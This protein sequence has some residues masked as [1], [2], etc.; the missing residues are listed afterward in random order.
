M[1]R[2]ECVRAR[3]AYLRQRGRAAG[4]AALLHRPRAPGGQRLSCL[5][6]RGNLMRGSCVRAGPGCACVGVRAVGRLRAS[7]APH[8]RRPRRAIGGD[9]RVDETRR[10]GRS[11]RV[12][13]GSQLDPEGA[14]YL[15]RPHDDA[16]AHRSV[17]FMPSRRQVAP[18]RE[19]VCHAL[20]AHTRRSEKSFG[21][22][23]TR[24]IEV[25]PGASQSRTRRECRTSTASRGHPEA[26]Q[27]L[28]VGSEAV[29]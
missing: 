27:K 13:F 7:R 15:P 12:Y 18:I 1:Q 8:R 28:S 11:T 21:M 26:L 20:T 4:R 3:A 29:Q 16:R 19:E 2:R 5:S 17:L 23:T 9:Q 14:S 25:S 22:C 10:G 24:P 6:A